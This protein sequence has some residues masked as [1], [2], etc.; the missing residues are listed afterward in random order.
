MADPLYVERGGHR[1]WLKWHRARR[2]ASDPV[3]LGRRVLEGMAL[4]ASVEV[5][6]VVHG[7]Q[8]FA[9]LHDLVLDRETT[10]RGSVRG[11]SPQTLRALH[12][13][14]NDSEPLPDAVMLL[15]DLCALLANTPPHTNALLQ[16]DYKED[17][18]ALD[19]ATIA[20]FAASVGPAAGNMIVSGADMAAIDAFAQATPGLRTGYDPC[21]GE[22]LA[23]LRASGD[24]AG[25]IADALAAAPKADMIYLSY[26]I[27]LAA[28]AAGV[29]VVAP[30]HADGRRI[31][32]WTIRTVDTSSLA[33]VERLLALKVDQITTDDPEG[34]LAAISP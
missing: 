25:F 33:Q 8:G 14:G 32:A 26:E 9:I 30:I 15:E 10:G 31:D 2:R 17:L 13:R 27:V 3:F 24:Y 7:G 29:D 18:A 4:G 28:E 11:T 12:L 19:G 23:K 5:D 20:N 22:P 21:Y 6:L 16:L 1:T 34:L